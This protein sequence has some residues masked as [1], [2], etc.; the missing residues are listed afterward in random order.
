MPADQKEVY[1]LMAPSRDAA[2]SSPYFEVFRAKGIE[3]LFFYEAIDDFVMERLMEFE[4]K[5]LVPA[6]K[7][8][9]NAPEP[10]GG[11]ACLSEADGLALAKWI[12]EVLGGAIEEVRVSKR[13]VGSPAMVLLREK[14]MTATMR[15]ILLALR[16][17]EAGADAAKFA[18]DLEINPRH[19]LIRRLQTMRGGDE[20]LARK[21]AEQLLDNARLTVGLLEDPRPML[22]RL[23]ELLE[24]LSTSP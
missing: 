11:S 13:L 22:Q 18:L 8:D 15:H 7:A 19:A 4:G 24:R 3:V 12:K 2:E 21:I 14:Q 6:E 16:P 5:S 20:A 17:A 10:E 23:N 1:Y 9:V